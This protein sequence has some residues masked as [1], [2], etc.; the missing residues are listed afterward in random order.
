ML[1]YFADLKYLENPYILPLISLLALL[2]IF[3]FILNTQADNLN[4]ILSHN[5]IALNVDQTHTTR[6]FLTNKISKPEIFF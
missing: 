4:K 1:Y 6:I 3:Y 5:V 2:I